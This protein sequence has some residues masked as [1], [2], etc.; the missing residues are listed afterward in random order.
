MQMTLPKNSTSIQIP[1]YSGIAL[2]VISMLFLGRDTASSSFWVQAAAILAAPAFFYFVGALVYRTLNAP[3]AAPGIVAT[4]AWLIGVALIH[5]DGKRSL[6]DPSLQDYYWLSASM[7][8]AV[9]IT[10][11]GHRIGTRLLMPLMPL[12]QINAMWALLGAFGVSVAWIPPLSFVLVYVWWEM[13]FRDS[14]WSNAYRG[15]AVLFTLFLLVFN[16][17]LPAATGESR[18]AA[19][20]AGAVVVALIG[21]RHG[22]TR[23]APLAI[24]MLAVAVA[25]G[26]PQ[27]LWSPL[28]LILASAAVIV[29]ERTQGSKEKGKGAKTVELTEALAVLL[30]GIAAGFAAT[31]P[32]FGVMMH[33]LGVVGVLA[34]SGVLLV[35]LGWRRGLRIS[36]HVGLWLTASAWGSLYFIAVPYSGTFGLWLALFASVALLIERLLTSR[37]R[38]KRKAPYSLVETVIRWPFA[39]LVI[40]LS[41]IILLWSAINIEA[42][43]PAI[44]TITLSIA[45]GTWIAAGM[46]Y[47]LP[48]LLHVALWIA[49]IPFALLLMLGA[50]ALYTLP[51]MGVAWQVLALIYLLIGHL[52]PRY[53]PSMLAPFFVAGYGLLGVGLVIALASPVLV[54]LT[55]GIVILTSIG[56]SAAVIFDLHPAWNVFVEGIAP[57]DSRP[58]AHRHIHSLFLFLSAWFAAV[59]IQLMLGYTDMTLSRQG[60]F[61]VV[62]AGLFFLIG[63]ALSRLPGVALWSVTSAGWLLWGIGLLQVFF[64]PPEAIITLILGLALSGEAM[65]RTRSMA[66][67]P[68]IILNVFVAALQIA[69][70]LGLPL[71]APLMA[72][73]VG[74]AL[75]GAWHERKSRRIGRVVAVT[76]IGL[77]LVVTGFQLDALSLVGLL[78]LAAGLAMLYREP[79]WMYAAYGMIAMLL[80]PTTLPIY[81]PTNQIATVLLIDSTILGLAALAIRIITAQRQPIWWLRPVYHLSLI[82]AALSI[83]LT[84]VALLFADLAARYADGSTHDLVKLMPLV[85]IAAWCFLSYWQN[86]KVGYIGLALMPITLMWLNFIPNELPV[87]LPIGITLMFMARRM[88][89]RH[90]NLIELAGVMILLLGAVNGLDRR[91][92]LS[93]PTIL[94]VAQVIIVVM[95]GTLGGRRIPFAAAGMVLAVGLVAGIAMINLW[96][97]PLAGGGLL[98]GVAL[99]VESQHKA[100]ESIT[101][102]VKSHWQAWK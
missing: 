38:E 73:A 41:A 60:V 71:H 87:S 55:L 11:T 15:Y 44:I 68:V 10:L 85:L 92:L 100:A 91:A 89:S 64:S 67:I 3:L 53:R 62:F 61:L 76:G 19:W 30:S 74:I 6:L 1:L 79:L 50:P 27:A 42:V 52:S 65:S 63:R 20:G 102:A 2:I 57:Y 80:L 66:W 72:L 14:M 36:T 22:W 82:L 5:L 70:L 94:F 25:W 18:M 21:L 59:W 12:A 29:I 33:P 47:R 8:A 88:T 101:L 84:V 9:L 23:L 26:M 13:P 93:L 16:L 69:W 81:V 40:G 98:I 49:P 17:W 45:I 35:W 86:R 37:Q 32:M 39:D 28:W 7:I 97:I 54:P 78:V 51:L 58:F 46:I 4:G 48:V 34:A 96:L 99:F 77:A 43:S 75:G 90:S 56:T 83:A 95:Y 31:A 24:V